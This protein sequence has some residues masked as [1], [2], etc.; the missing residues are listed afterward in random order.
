MILKKKKSVQL[1][2][3]L[4]FYILKPQYSLTV[5]EFPFRLRNRRTGKL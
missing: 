4:R 5:G 1:E 2:K 3:I